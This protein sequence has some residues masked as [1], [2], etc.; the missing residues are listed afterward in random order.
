MKRKKTP[1][2][3]AQL[4]HLDG[5]ERTKL[6]K[7]ASKL[8][9]M[10]LAH[11]G[12]KSS[13]GDL[14]GEMTRAPAPIPSDS[15]AGT[16]TWVGPK[17][18]MVDGKEADLNGF[19]LAAGDLAHV[20]PFEDR[21]K[22]VGVE[23]RRTK[24]SRPDVQNPHLERVI[25]AN[26]DVVVIVVSVGTPPL[27]P[28]LIDRYLVAIQ[29]GGAMPMIVVNKTDLLPPADLEVEVQK[30]VPYAALE[31]PILAVSVETG[32]GL[33]AL[34]ESLAGKTCAFVGHSGVGKSSLANGLFPE[35]DLKV[36]GLMRNY[37]RGAHTTT[38][39]SLFDV[40]D[41]TRL[42]DTP[43]IRS[44]GL[45]KMSRQELQLAFPEFERF[46][47]RFRDC[48]HVHEPGCGVQAAVDAG[49]LFRERYET[50]LRLL[51]EVD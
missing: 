17:T 14:L 19:R 44:F 39:S 9:K 18:A 42:I 36:G 47:C 5:N 25:V 28:R 12:R 24:L 33:D 11:G 34:R 10:A 38:T 7:Q 15:V 46:A 41:G 23:D 3:L 50:F 13:L 2:H 26:V 37:G 40:G 22:V 43:G 48:S 35:L 8:R 20:S 21:L 49:D 31:V 30:T 16:V 51:E 6:L 32:Q 4:G 1:Y 29:M 45:G 27:H